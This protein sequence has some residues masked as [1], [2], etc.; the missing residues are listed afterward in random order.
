MLFQWPP[1]EHWIS[2]MDFPEVRLE[3]MLHKPLPL[4]KLCKLT[5]V[6]DELKLKT[7]GKLW[8]LMHMDLFVCLL[9]LQ[10]VKIVW[11]DGIKMGWYIFVG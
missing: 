1:R 6:D 4:E 8:W 10:G 9:K 11:E 7:A 3:E 2:H 5:E